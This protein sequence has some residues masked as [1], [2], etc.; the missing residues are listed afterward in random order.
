MTAETR[1]IVLGDDGRPVTL[2]R[3]SE[4]SEE[5]ILAVTEALAWQRM[6]SWPIEWIY[7]NRLSPQGRMTLTGFGPLGKPS[8]SVEVAAALAEQKRRPSAGQGAP[9]RRRSRP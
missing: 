1:T 6:S 4:P 9:I 3:Y 2:G 5:E 8:E 7:G